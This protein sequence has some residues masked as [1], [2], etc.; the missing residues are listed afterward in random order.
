MGKKKKY[1]ENWHVTIHAWFC[2]V[3]SYV[4]NICMCVWPAPPHLELVLDHCQLSATSSSVDMCISLPE[5]VLL[6]FPHG[7]QAVQRAV[8]LLLRP[9][10]QE[11]VSSLLIVFT[12][13]RSYCANN[14]I[15]SQVALL[16]SHVLWTFRQRMSIV[17]LYGLPGFISSAA[18]RLLFVILALKTAMFLVSFNLIC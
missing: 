4:I 12:P 7:H 18:W 14:F 16:C 1:T 3:D 11:A 8:V 9:R 15:N 17:W 10:E 2:T 13:K 5:L 6:F